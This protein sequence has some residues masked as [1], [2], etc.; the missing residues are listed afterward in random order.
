M[1]KY[2]PTWKFLVDSNPETI[3]RWNPQRNVLQYAGRLESKKD[4]TD[5]TKTDLGKCAQS[6]IKVV[7]INFE[8][9]KSINITVLSPNGTSHIDHNHCLNH[10][11]LYQK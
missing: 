8:I 9:I 11:V 6:M 2:T 10:H 3:I 7:L 1:E 5:K 4:K